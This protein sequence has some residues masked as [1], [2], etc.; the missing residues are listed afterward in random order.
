MLVE[1]AEDLQHALAIQALARIAVAGAQRMGNRHSKS[2]VQPCLT[3]MLHRFHRIHCTD[4]IYR[5]RT[6]KS[7]KSNDNAWTHDLPGGLY[8]TVPHGNAL[9]RA[10]IQTSW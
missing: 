4:A 2:M 10:T 3:V 9:C 1:V 8:G 5:V 7:W 6:V